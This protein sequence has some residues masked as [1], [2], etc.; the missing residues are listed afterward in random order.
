MDTKLLVKISNI[1]GLVATILLVYWIFTFILTQ[2][3]GLKIFREHL[4]NS[5]QLSIFG[6]LALMA[7]A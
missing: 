3:F 1:I 4:T 5:F 2:V 6:I 7:G